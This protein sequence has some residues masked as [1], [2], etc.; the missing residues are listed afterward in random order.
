MNWKVRLSD[1]KAIKKDMTRSLPGRMTLA[2]LVTAMCALI[3]ATVFL[4]WPHWQKYQAV[5][6]LVQ[7]VTVEPC[8]CIYS[9]IGTDQLAI[10]STPALDQH[11]QRVKRWHGTR[12]VAEAL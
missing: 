8:V 7:F 11:V 2:V 10:K 4:V 12:D 9:S 1:G 3:G 5:K 6:R